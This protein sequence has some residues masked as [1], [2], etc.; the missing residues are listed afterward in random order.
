MLLKGLCNP[1]LVCKLFVMT[2]QTS[3][4]LL[5]NIYTV[6][7]QIYGKFMGFKVLTYQL[8]EL[9]LLDRSFKVQSKVQAKCPLNWT[10]PDC[11][12][13]TQYTA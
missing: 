7:L 4:N 13:T 1:P 9:N 5:Y 12:I 11:G 6:F 2:L 3:S 10:K 8:P